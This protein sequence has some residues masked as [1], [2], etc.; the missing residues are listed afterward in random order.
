MKSKYNYHIEK[1]LIVKLAIHP[2]PEKVLTANARRAVYHNTKTAP[3][4]YRAN[5]VKYRFNEKGI[6]INNETN[7]PVLKNARLVGTPRYW[8]V[9]FQDIWNQTVTR[10]RR[11]ILTNKLKDMVTSSLNH[12]PVITKFPIATEIIIRHLELKQDVDNK[13][14][15]YHKVFADTLKKLGKIPDD[16]AQYINESGKTTFVQV[17]NIEDVGMDY[18]IYHHTIKLIN[19]TITQ[20]QNE[21]PSTQRRR[22]RQA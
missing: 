13:G 8:H 9:N 14:V 4:T 21:L 15:I 5:K 6:L 18:N 16:N 3:P 12:C 10:E 19:P 7:M 1:E 11:A 2:Y 17:Y 22:T 20:K